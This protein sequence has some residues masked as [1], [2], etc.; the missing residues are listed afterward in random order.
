VRPL[1]RWPT[2]PGAQ[3]WSACARV[4]RP[5]GELGE[6]FA[7][8]LPAVSRHLEVP[9]TAGLIVRGRESQWRLRRPDADPTRE[10][11][12]RTDGYRRVWEESFER[13]DG[14]LIEQGSRP[15]KRKDETGAED[16]HVP[17]VRGQGR[18]GN[19]VLRLP[20]PRLEGDQRRPHPRRR[21]GRRLPD[22]RPG[23]QGAAG[24]ADVQVHRGHLSLYVKCDDQAEVDRLWSK[25]LE[26]GGQEQQCG[27]LK[28]RF[29]LS[30]QIIPNGLTELM[31]D[32]DPVKS[33]RVMQA[34]L[35]M[36]KIDVEGLRRA[37]R[38]D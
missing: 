2:R 30:W 14:L 26:G 17:L 8:S 37:H 22:G 25:L 32:P 19:G 16:R 4:R 31:S 24:R 36:V 20:L 1:Q 38:G 18:G 5:V 7:I 35:G 12:E 34:M 11:A 9:E 28:D 15:A 6:P 33:G 3:S 27:W 10:V 29:G 21:R 23:V 13:L